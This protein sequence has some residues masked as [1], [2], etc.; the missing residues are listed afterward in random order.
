[1]SNSKCLTLTQNENPGSETNVGLQPVKVTTLVVQR[2]NSIVTQTIPI[3]NLVV[4]QP[5]PVTSLVVQQPVPVT[6]ITTQNIVPTIDKASRRGKR[7][8]LPR[9]KRW[10]L[11][12]L[13]ER[14]TLIHDGKYDYSLIK[15]ENVVNAYS[16]V[17]IRCKICQYVWLG[18]IHYHINQENGCSSCSGKL[19]WTLPRFLY[20]AM[21]IHGNKF[22]YSLVTVEFINCVDS[23]VPVVCNTCSTLFTPTIDNHI[24]NQSGCPLCGGNLRWE[25]N[26]FIKRA[27]EI[28]GIL[29]NYCY[30]RIED[31]QNQYSIVILH[32]NTCNNNWESTIHNHI[33]NRSGCP[34]CNMS[35]GE[36]TTRVVLL[37]WGL[38]P[39]KQ[40]VLPGLSNRHYDFYFFWNNIHY[41]IEFD[42]MQHFVFVPFLQVD[43]S[44]FFAQQASD[45]EKTKHALNLGY[46]VIRL[47]YTQIKHLET[48]L[49]AALQSPTMFYLSTPSMYTYIM[50]ML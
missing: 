48:H 7:Y 16:K 50:D 1:M 40:K 15:E 4:Q 17:L 26:R 18:C 41:I 20:R 10:T 43:E 24:N 45:I 11:A 32:C 21:Q 47:D 44:K 31:I 36:Q 37:K 49:T 19:K 6:T 12:I 22:D 34:Y 35:I 25:Y 2:P 38:S 23:K 28:H 3:T 5:I 39:E 46:K 13:I 14:G 29:Y 30:I 42:G 8:N 33:Y 9:V 27:Q